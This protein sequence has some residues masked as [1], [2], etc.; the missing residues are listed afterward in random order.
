MASID[1]EEKRQFQ[2]MQLSSQL[3]FRRTGIT[4]IFKGETLD[5]SATGIRFITT[6]PLENA[7]LLQLVIN[8]KHPQIAPLVAEGKV[9]RTMALNE[10][11]DRFEISLLFTEL[12]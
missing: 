1:H 3:Q 7:E 10:A 4:Q 2:R 8:S 6:E 9:L 12:N 11:A 5:L